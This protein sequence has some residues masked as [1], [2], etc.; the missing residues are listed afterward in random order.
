MAQRT[1]VM[2]VDDLDGSN[3]DE[4]LEFGLDGASY[5]IDLTDVHAGAL[6]TRSPPSSPMPDAPG[7][8]AVPQFRPAA[9][10]PRHRSRRRPLPADASRTKP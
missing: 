3:A 4:S 2:L 8:V 7:A 1:T 10:P 5:E 6:A 9:E